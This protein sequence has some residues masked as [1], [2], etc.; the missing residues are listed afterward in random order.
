MP[1]EIF[2]WSKIQMFKLLHI[3]AILMTSWFCLFTHSAAIAKSKEELIHILKHD[4]GSCH[5]MTLKGGLGPNLLSERL[6]LQSLESIKNTILLGRPGT[7]MP[8]W[9]NLLSTDD[10]EKMAVLLREGEVK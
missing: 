1:L 3:L 7:A 10:I 6:K 5:G 4:C 9:Q 2:L 8:P